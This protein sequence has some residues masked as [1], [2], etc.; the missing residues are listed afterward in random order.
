MDNLKV[1]HN[2]FSYFGKKFARLSGG[3]IRYTY[4]TVVEKCCQ[5]VVLL[6]VVHTFTLEKDAFLVY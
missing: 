4:H 5:I 6:L 1:E 3:L 2:N